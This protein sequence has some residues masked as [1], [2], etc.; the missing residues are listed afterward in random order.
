MYTHTSLTCSRS[1]HDKT[2]IYKYRYIHTN[3]HTQMNT[4]INT[5]ALPAARASTTLIYRC[6]Y[7]RIDIHIQIRTHTYIYIYIH[8]RALPAAGASTTHNTHIY[9]YTPR[10]TTEIYIY[11]HTHI[12]THK[13]LTCSRS[14]H[15]RIHGIY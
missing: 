13:S 14:P 12:Y 7:T 11:T 9:I 6:T 1:L 5:Q 15:D 10:H 3:T 4:C 8:T 2:Y